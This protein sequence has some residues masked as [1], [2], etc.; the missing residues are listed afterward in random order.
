MD[1]HC[2]HIPIYQNEPCVYNIHTY[3][4]ISILMRVLAKLHEAGGY[5]IIFT[6]NRRYTH[7]VTY[8]SCKMCIIFA[9]LQV[10]V[11]LIEYIVCRVQ[12][13]S[14]I[15]HRMVFTK[16]VY[17]YVYMYMCEYMSCWIQSV[18]LIQNEHLKIVIWVK[19]VVY[20][21]GGLDMLCRENVGKVFF[22]SYKPCNADYIQC[23][24]IRDILVKHTTA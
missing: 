10:K 14:V 1:V 12:N 3:T 4:H 11:K 2:T 16:C 22:F 20:V 5:I 15:N 19:R 24:F 18:Y 13:I 17:S 8:I 7:G 21:C 23:I 6:C 9:L